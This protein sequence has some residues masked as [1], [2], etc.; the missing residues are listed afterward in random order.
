MV[1]LA[2]T[3]KGLAEAMRTAAQ[4]EGAVWCSANALSEEEFAKM[5]APN[6]TR[7]TYVIDGKNQDQLSDALAT[8]EEHHPG[9][10]VWV[11]AT[12]T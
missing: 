12:R 5:S 2:F 4:I 10:C 11:E 1:F 9:Q 8:I 3:S 7:F 6:L